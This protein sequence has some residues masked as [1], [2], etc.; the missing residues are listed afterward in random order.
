MLSFALLLSLVPL[1]LLLLLLLLFEV[2]VLLGL[3]FVRLLSC[4]RRRFSLAEEFDREFTVFRVVFVVAAKDALFDTGVGKRVDDKD[5]DE[6]RSSSPSSLFTGGGRR[7]TSSR[8]TCDVDVW[9]EFD[10]LL[11]LVVLAA[12]AVAVEL[13]GVVV[14][15]AAVLCQF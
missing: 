2:A 1:I 6:E 7:P 3:L 10:F 14:L 8:H 15:L 13:T 9:V 4:C 11:P 5:K 12:V